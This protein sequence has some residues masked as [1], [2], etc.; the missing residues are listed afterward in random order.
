M[1]MVMEQYNS[2]NFY[3]L[4]QKKFRLRMKNNKYLKHLSYLIE[5]EMEKFLYSNSSLCL[6]I[7][8]KIFHNKNYNKWFVVQTL[9]VM[10]E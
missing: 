1:L 5:T 7:L 9:I 2:N 4:C 8:V 6:T 3:K 10:D